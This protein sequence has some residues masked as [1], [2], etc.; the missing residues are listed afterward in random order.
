MANR[1]K[2]RIRRGDTVL[3]LAG[4]D[5]GRKG[6]VTQ[7]LPDRRRVL[8]EG[9]NMIRRHVKSTA[10]QPGRIMEREAALDISNVAFWDSERECRV[11][12][13]WKILE[14]G[15]KVRVDRKTGEQIDNN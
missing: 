4:K 10:E 6:R 11:K 14:D 13:G 15:S 12:I 2:F 9:M 7:V 8:V 5:K 1:L 3:V